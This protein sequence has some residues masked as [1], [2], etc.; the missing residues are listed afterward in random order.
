MVPE[1]KA[2]KLPASW[3]QKTTAS[4]LNWSMV[5]AHLVTCAIQAVQDADGAL[6]T[7]C[8]RDHTAVTITLYF[9]K[10][11]GTNYYGTVDKLEAALD[12]IIDTYASSAEDIRQL[13]GL[14]GGS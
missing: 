12:E 6:M 1:V 2:R 10:V 5:N 3:G 4:A 7:G 13:F 11:R 8:T 9:G 14:A